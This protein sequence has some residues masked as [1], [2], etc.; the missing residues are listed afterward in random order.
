MYKR[1]E[2]GTGETPFFT[3]KVKVFYTGW[4][5]NDWSKADTYTD[6]KNN[7]IINK[8]IFDST[9]LDP[10]GKPKDNIIPREFEIKTL[11]DGFSTALQYMKIGDKWEVWIPW[12]LGYGAFDNRN[13]GIKAHTT[14]V[15]EIELV[16]IL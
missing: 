8:N 2:S 7:L 6:D 12:N 1:I 10:N 11:V 16:E 3:D 15:F 14:L 4:Y 5:K 13:S 9:N